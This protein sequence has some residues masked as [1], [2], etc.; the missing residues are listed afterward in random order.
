M[1]DPSGDPFAQLPPAVQRDVWARCIRNEYVEDDIVHLGG[2]SLDGRIHVLRSGMVRYVG[3]DPQGRETT[4]DVGGPGELIGLSP[5]LLG[6]PEPCDVLAV[7]RCV[8]YSFPGH[9]AVET[10]LSHREAVRTLITQVVKMQNR[11]A[12]SAVER[13]MGRLVERLAG[14]LLHVHNT[15]PWKDGAPISHTRLAQLAGG[16]RERVC[17]AMI[18]L[19]A[20]GIID[21]DKESLRVL[22]PEELER[23]RFGERV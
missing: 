7:A 18:E 4:V 20:A 23:L 21:Y 15:E 9:L 2:H 17:R 10:L 1:Y 12:A 22:K 5:I 3:R 13:S 8:T 11:G 14:Q 16:S 6:A 19:R